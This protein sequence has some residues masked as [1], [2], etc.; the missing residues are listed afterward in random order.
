MEVAITILTRALGF[1]RQV[2]NSPMLWTP[3]HID[4]ATSINMK[5]FS[6]IN[7]GQLWLNHHV[8]PL[9]ALPAQDKATITSTSNLI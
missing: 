4:V 2:N 1:G 5:L 8:Q 7:G 6:V 3:R 9:F